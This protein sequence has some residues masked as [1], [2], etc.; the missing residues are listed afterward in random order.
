MGFYGGQ[1]TVDPQQFD[2]LYP[3]SGAPQIRSGI[4]AG[5]P[6]AM[7]AATDAGLRA[8][9]AGTDAAGALAPAVG[10]GKSVLDGNYLSSPQLL[11]Y[12][13]GTRQASDAGFAA[14]KAAGDV[15]AQN[16]REQAVAGLGAQQADTR[17]SFGR[18]G[19][20]FGTGSEL[21]QQGQMAATQAQLARAETERQSGVT[22]ADAQRQ[23]GLAQ[24]ENQAKAQQFSQERGFQ[25]AAP[26]I[27]GQ[28]GAQATNLLAAV[29]GQ[30]Y[31]G[32]AP[33]AQ[34]LQQLAG[35]GQVVNPNTYYKPGVGDYALQAA[36]TAGAAGAAGVM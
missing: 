3:A 22:A 25:Q 17:A 14:T 13:Q 31:S 4:F 32:V 28:A 26:G 24:S 18:N 33:A 34:I 12:L 27:I 2:P 19:Q 21:A 9:Q 15:T 11:N 6:G 20:A 29:P 36:G 35:N 10:Y 7:T 1:K 23:A 30:M 8:G 5:L 16:T